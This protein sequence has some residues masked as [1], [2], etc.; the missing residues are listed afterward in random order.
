MRRDVE[1]L[2]VAEYLSGRGGKAD[3]LRIIILAAEEMRNFGVWL[4]SGAAATGVGRPELFYYA[5]S[6]FP[7]REK[8][9]PRAAPVWAPIY[10]AKE[11]P[12]GG[13]LILG[14]RCF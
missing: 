4:L 10:Y 12:R 7:G 6:V 3:F 9:G 5:R 2:C 14:R 13:E 8:S 1:G 11:L